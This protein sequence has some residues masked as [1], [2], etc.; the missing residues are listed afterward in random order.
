MSLKFLLEGKTS[1][2]PVNFILV[3]NYQ[4]YYPKIDFEFV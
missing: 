1:N 3:I 4:I 2:L